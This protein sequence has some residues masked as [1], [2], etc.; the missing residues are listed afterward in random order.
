MAEC[1]QNHLKSIVKWQHQCRPPISHQDAVLGLRFCSEESWGRG[2]G[3]TAGVRLPAASAGHG[4]SRNA[5][6]ACC[7]RR[8]SGTP[9]I[10][11][12]RCAGR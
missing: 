6:L 9:D 4:C 3:G 8:E 12:C 10:C 1:L 11:R 5:F 7:L 2:D